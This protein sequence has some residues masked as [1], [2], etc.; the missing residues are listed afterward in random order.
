MLKTGGRDGIPYKKCQNC[1]MKCSFEG[2]LDQELLLLGYLVTNKPEESVF[3]A[4]LVFIWVFAYTE[5]YYK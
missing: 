1:A 2:L 3:V 4:Y 5:H